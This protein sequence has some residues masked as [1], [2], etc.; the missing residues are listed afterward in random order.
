MPRAMSSAMRTRRRSSSATLGVLHAPGLSLHAT[1]KV[2]GQ[3]DSQIECSVDNSRTLRARTMRVLL[4]GFRQR[5]YVLDST[6]C[7]APVPDAMTPHAIT[8][9]FNCLLDISWRCSPS[10]TMV[11]CG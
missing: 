5:L 1:A 6:G 2:T 3:G 7:T 8:Q 11:S 9:L 10:A 4:M